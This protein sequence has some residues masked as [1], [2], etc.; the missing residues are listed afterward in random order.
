MCVNVR[1]STSGRF[2]FSECR[3]IFLFVTGVPGKTKWPVAPASATAMFFAVFNCAVVYLVCVAAFRLG[4]FGGLLCFV[5]MLLC[6][7]VEKM[8]VRGNEN[9]R[10]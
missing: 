1:Q 9:G 7:T 10:E 2:I 3:A 4:R 5:D 6:R 8:T